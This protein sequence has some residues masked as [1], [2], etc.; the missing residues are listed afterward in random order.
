MGAIWILQARKKGTP[1]FLYHGRKFKVDG[2]ITA[3]T[4]DSPFDDGTRSGANVK[5]VNVTNGKKI[6]YGLL[7]PYMVERYGF[8]EGKGTRY[9]LEPSEVVAVFDFL[10]K[11]R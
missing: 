3:G 4:Q 10:K 11:K 5:V 1:E 2:I 9:R 6:G 8:Y 7:V